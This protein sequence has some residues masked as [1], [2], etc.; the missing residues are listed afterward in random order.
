MTTT[1]YAPIVTNTIL[2]SAARTAL[3]AATNLQVPD[4]CSHVEVSIVSTAQ[5]ASPTLTFTI[6][7]ADG[8]TLLA[9]A[10]TDFSNPVTL[11]LRYGLWLTAVN[12]LTA[13]GIPT[14]GMTVAVAVGDAD[15]CTYSVKA[16]YF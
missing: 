5:T 3:V 4:G 7:D 10:A 14:A 12:N 9:S 13:Q 1:A 8:A 11:I 2:A 6:K 15:S 16:R